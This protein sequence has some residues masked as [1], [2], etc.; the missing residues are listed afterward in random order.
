MPCRACWRSFCS[1]FS[2]FFLPPWWLSCWAGKL[3]WVLLLFVPFIIYS[4][5]K[6]GRHVR[7]T[8]R[9][10]QDK[11]ADIQNILQETI[12]GNRIVKAF[13]ME[14]WEMRPLPHRRAAL[15]PRQYAFGGRGLPSVPL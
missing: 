13:S 11:L 12:T 5:V 1:R 15:I 8:T 6:I 14:N 9:S 4:A 3:A 7:H 10:G 2:P